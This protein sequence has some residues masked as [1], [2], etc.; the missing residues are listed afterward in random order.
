MLQTVGG[1]TDYKIFQFS[2]GS[3]D[4]FVQKMA[5]NFEASLERLVASLAYFT[6]ALETKMS[7]MLYGG[8][9]FQAAYRHLL[10]ILTNGYTFPILFVIQYI[11]A[12]M[13]TDTWFQSVSSG[14]IG[15]TK[16]SASLKP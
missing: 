15:E 12:M 13:A 10:V 7:E 14:E 3:F 2:N 8:N 5:I 4:W 9:G 1:T 6:D 11:E 16:H